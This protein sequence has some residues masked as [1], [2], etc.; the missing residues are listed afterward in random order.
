M[1]KFLELKRSLAARRYNALCLYGNDEWVKRR[2][3]SNVCEAY[4]VQD[5]GFGVDWLE[6]PTAESLSLA[7]M[8]PSM[9]CPIKLVVC[10]GPFFPEAKETP[11]GGRADNKK[12]AEKTAELRKSLCNLLDNAD[13]SFCVV[14]LADSDKN[15][16]NINGLETVNCNRLDKTD[17]VRWIVSYAKRQGVAVDNLCAQLIADYCLLD[18]SRISVETQK[19]IDFG[20]VTPQSV[21]QLVHKDAEFAVYDLSEAIAAKN[22]RRATEI[23]RG[24]VSRGEEPRA[25][26]ALIYN[27]YRRVYY[28]KTS[29]FSNDELARYL[30]VKPA[31][32]GYA[33]ETASRYKAIQLSCALQYLAAADARIKAFADENEVMNLL[34]MQ[35]IS[36]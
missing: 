23:Y 26:F 35:L 33:K 31:S 22:A 4:G 12:I 8:T 30:G 16:L 25:L 15:F 24:L 13:G 2:A 34:I 21:E 29:A 1:I 14:F 11:S 9:F 5:D 6:Q 32:V 20:E 7:C 19:L 28:V 10:Q 27:F 3:L 36:L 18:M 17:V